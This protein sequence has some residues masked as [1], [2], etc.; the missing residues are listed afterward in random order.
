MS[1]LHPIAP[2]QILT[3]TH[4][5]SSSGLGARTQGEKLDM[6]TMLILIHKRSPSTPRP[7][8]GRSLPVLCDLGRALAFLAFSF[9]SWI[10]GTSPGWMV[11]GRLYLPNNL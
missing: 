5:L 8:A 2:L 3:G 11:P 4:R 6:V 10:R 1:E 7:H 9:L